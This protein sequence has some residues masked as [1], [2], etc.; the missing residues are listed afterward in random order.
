MTNDY[1]IDI[2]SKQEQEKLWN[3]WQVKDKPIRR[4]VAVRSQQYFENT[5][6]YP[7][8]EQKKKWVEKLNSHKSIF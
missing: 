3:M 7:T 5:G 1:N 6:K 2:P 8:S 4:K